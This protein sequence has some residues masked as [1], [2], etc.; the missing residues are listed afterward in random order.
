MVLD[1]FCGCGTAMAVAQ[2]L[3][4]K[5][6]GIDITHLAITLIKKRLKDQFDAES[7]PPSPPP[8]AGGNQVFPPFTG[9]QRGVASQRDKKRVACRSRTPLTPREQG[10][11]G[12]LPPFTGGQRGV[13][14]ELGTTFRRSCGNVRGR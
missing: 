3:N 2:K 12:S 7:D 1:P 5:W 13:A 9:G 4:R 14:S 6:I 11:N 10:G 8:R